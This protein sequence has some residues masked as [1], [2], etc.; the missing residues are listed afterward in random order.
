MIGKLCV[1]RV[2]GKRGLECSPLPC[3]PPPLFPYRDYWLLHSAE[4][5]SLPTA[6]CNLLSICLP[7]PAQ[8]ATAATLWQGGWGEGKGAPLNWGARPWEADWE[9]AKVVCTVSRSGC[10][11]VPRL[12]AANPLPR[13]SSSP[14]FAE[15]RQVVK[16]RAGQEHRDEGRPWTPAPRGRD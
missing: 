13:L 2:L 6:A 15:K 3:C 10:T 9:S 12:G 1:G 5:T 4:D 7:L 11:P 14:Q 16:I 8:A